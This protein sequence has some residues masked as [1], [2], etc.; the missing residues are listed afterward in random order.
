MVG[1]GGVL[2]KATNTLYVSGGGSP[3]YVPV[4]L[5]RADSVRATFHRR[6]RGTKQKEKH[7]L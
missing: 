6:L 2:Q 5:S 3:H 7:F 4:E 1:V